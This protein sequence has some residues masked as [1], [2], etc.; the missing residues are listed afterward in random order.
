MVSVL[1][2]EDNP[3][4]AELIREM[5]PPGE[6]RVDHVERLGEAVVALGHKPYD[7]LLLDLGLPDSQGVGAV[8]RI[9]RRHLELPVVVLTGLA[10]EEAAIR[11]LRAGAQDYLVKGEIGPDQAVRAIHRAMARKEV[12]VHKSRFL[13][14]ISHEMRT[15]LNFILGA[16]SCLED[17]VAGEL[18]GQQRKLVRTILEGGDRLLEL[19]NDLLDSAQILAGR[20]EVE[21]APTAIAPIVR[22]AVQ[23]AEAAA[24]E[25]SLE[26]VSANL[27]DAVVVGDARRIRQVVTNLLSNALKFTPPGGAITV[28]SCLLAGRLC[29]EVSDSGIGIPAD[30]RDQVFLR[31]SQLQGPGSPL[32]KGTGL[33]LSISKA[34]VEALGGDIGVESREGGGSTFWFTLPVLGETALRASL[35]PA[36]DIPSNLRDQER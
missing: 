9:V 29:V 2:V 3:G 10:D 30:A 24:R 11:A 33:G 20:F 6:F 5:L 8:D 17:G 22:D 26:L 13:S 16:A 1:L 25:R 15:P 18:T 7:L 12:E 36:E 4:D 19:I 32:R 14:V 34:I 23:A 35:L 27:H 31:F 21:R 28:R